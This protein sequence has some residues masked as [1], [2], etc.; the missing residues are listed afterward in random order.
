MRRHIAAVFV[1]VTEERE[2]GGYYTLSST[3]ISP[4]AFPE[5]IQKRLPKY[6]HMPATLLGRLAVAKNSAAGD[7]AICF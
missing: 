6:K 7:T 5:E 1:L 3:A 2:I 4:E